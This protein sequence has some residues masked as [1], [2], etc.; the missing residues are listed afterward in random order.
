[1]AGAVGARGLAE[2]DFGSADAALLDLCRMATL[3]D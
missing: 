1:V 3:F 2:I